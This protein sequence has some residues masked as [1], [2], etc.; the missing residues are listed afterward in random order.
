MMHEVDAVI[1]TSYQGSEAF[2][3]TAEDAE[4]YGF[5]DTGLGWESDSDEEEEQLL[6]PWDY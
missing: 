3:L 2:C 1:L 6:L 5:R 4:E